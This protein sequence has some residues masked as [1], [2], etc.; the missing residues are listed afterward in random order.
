MMLCRLDW[1]ALL[2]RVS[3]GWVLSSER[4]K[5]S[6]FVALNEQCKVSDCADHNI[7]TIAAGPSQCLIMDILNDVMQFGLECFAGKG[8]HRL[9]IEL[10]VIQISSCSTKL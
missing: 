9:G 2:A 3:T 1:N 6:L 8:L 10:A 7:Q 5:S 4:V